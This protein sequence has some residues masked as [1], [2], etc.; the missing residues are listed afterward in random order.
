MSSAQKQ[1][2]AV[3]SRLGFVLAALALA[4]VHFTLCNHFVPLRAVLAPAPL[5][6]DDFDLH[7]GQ[8][9]RVLQGLDGWGKAWV[10]DVQLLAGQPEGTIFD[11]DNKGCEIFTYALWKLGLHEAVAFNLFVWLSTALGPLVVFAAARVFGFAP[12]SSLLSATLACLLWFFDSFSHWVWFVGMFSYGLASYLTLLPLA[13]FHRFC[14]QRR[15]RDAALSGV[16]LGVVHL[17]HPYSFFVLALPM[18]VTYLRCARTLG[19]V[20]HAA[21]AGAAMFTLGV[22]AYWLRAALSHWHYVLDSAYYGQTGLPYLVAD[23]FDL[24]RDPSDT[25]VIGTRSGVRFLCFG[26]AFC[27][28]LALHR[29][30]DRR[31]LPLGLAFITLLI[32]GYFGA[33]LPGARQL[34]PYRHVMPAAFVATLLAAAFA[35][36]LHAEKAL[37]A[38]P[39]SVKALLV[40]A[41]FAVVQHLGVEA[42]YYL[43][44]LAPD[45][46]ALADG[47]PT[48]ITKYGFLDPF[49]GHSHVSYV[50]PHPDWLE[51]QAEDVVQWVAHNVP[52][53]ARLLVDNAVLGER[54]AWKT[55]AEVLGGFRERNIAHAYANLFRRYG[56]HE[57]SSQELERYLRTFG[58]SFI[59]TQRPRKDFAAA[60]ELLEP[61]PPVAG[62]MVYRT[63]PQ[64]SQVLAGGGRVRASTNRIELRGSDPTRDAILAYH[65]HE[66]LRCEPHCRVE[67]ELVDLD[68]VGFVRVPAPH[69]ADFTLVNSYR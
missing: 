62:R 23:F 45:V 12:W 54:I 41:T 64:V 43:P 24:L 56:D 49:V 33:Y 39:R 52:A 34:Q 50:L 31:A 10:Y 8:T 26:A 32:L 36:A 27:G 16:L 11:A 14:E 67:R 20:E 58:V 21:V 66:A 17:V 1:S 28:L 25:G 61:Q 5:Q 69:P 29:A 15:L 2:P 46:P 37:L 9:Y 22:N 48:P 18:A 65:F 57:L 38:L 55:K 68:A 35:E 30:R 3:A 40:V 19:R 13:L 47:A 7:I 51:G 4:G 63:R 60:T 59:I 6:G 53:G 42:V 44:E